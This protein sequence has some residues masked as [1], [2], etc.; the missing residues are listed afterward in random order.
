MTSTWFRLWPVLFLVLA[1]GQVQAGEL[2]PY[3]GKAEPAPLRLK[4]LSGRV[5]TLAQ[6]KGEVVL[7][8]FWATWCPPC[9][10]EMPSMW[11]L[12]NRFRD[13]PFT[14]VA[15]DMGDSLES[16]N[17]FLPDAMKRDFVVL[18]DED[19]EALKAWK[20]FAFPTSYLLDR[21]GRIRYALYGALEW[22]EPEVVEV[23]EKLLSEK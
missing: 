3:K 19:G 7:V 17:T 10:I 15:V 18:M 16:V 23:V 14:V 22:D 21:Q 6:H 13:R 1:A 9:R 11:R 12:K 5:H 2:K 20:V 4:D 8:N